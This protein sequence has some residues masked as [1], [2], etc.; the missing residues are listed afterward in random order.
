VIGP[1]SVSSS[2]IATCAQGY[3]GTVAVHAVAPVDPT[4]PPDTPNVPVVRGTVNMTCP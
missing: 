3:A 2:G 1:I 4:L